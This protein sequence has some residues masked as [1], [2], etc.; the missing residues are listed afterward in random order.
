MVTWCLVKDSIIQFDQMN[1]FIIKGYGEDSVWWWWW[2]N[3]ESALKML[4]GYADSVL[5][6]LNTVNGYFDCLSKQ[7]RRTGVS[8]GKIYHRS[9]SV[10]VVAIV[11]FA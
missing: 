1:F 10:Q 7:S 5:E 11:E 3:D 2:P 6:A 4:H 9:N 8:R